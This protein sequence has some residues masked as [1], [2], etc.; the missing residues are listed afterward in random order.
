MKD[1]YSV[2]NIDSSASPLLIDAAYE[3]KKNHQDI[4]N[5]D[6]DNMRSFVEARRAHNILSN[7]AYRFLYDIK[8]EVKDRYIISFD[9][10]SEIDEFMSIIESV[11]VK[12]HKQSTTQIKEIHRL[13]QDIRGLSSKNT[14][15]ENELKS[16]IKKIENKTNE[17]AGLKTKTKE[18][19]A[20]IE[21][22]DKEI[23]AINETAQWLEC[24]NERYSKLLKR[25]G[26]NT[27]KIVSVVSAIFLFIIIVL[28][29]NL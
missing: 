26:I 12:I 29:I 27:F 16:A 20:L 21:Q 22:K 2:L 3:H 25:T 13:H 17:I 15:T 18:F 4:G 8:T 9:S 7:K 24:K 28:F 10:Q 23:S 11:L 19:L 14:D 5:S 1:F 6:Y